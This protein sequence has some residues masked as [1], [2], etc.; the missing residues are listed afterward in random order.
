M[1]GSAFV[2]GSRQTERSAILRPATQ[3]EWS[4]MCIS[5]QRCTFL[6]TLSSGNKAGV[7]QR[8]GMFPER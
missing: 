7:G 1:G 2:S 8:L 6:R 5:A 3:Q 4:T